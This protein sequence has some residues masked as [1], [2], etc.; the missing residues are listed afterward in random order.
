MNDEQDNAMGLR[1]YVHRLLDSNELMLR[2]TQAA[3]ELDCAVLDRPTDTGFRAAKEIG[4]ALR[5]LSGAGE[6][7]HE[8][9]LASM[10]YAETMERLA[11]NP[12]REK[13]MVELADLFSCDD[14]KEHWAALRD[15]CNVFAMRVIGHRRSRQ[16]IQSHPLFLL[17]HGL[18]SA[19]SRC[20]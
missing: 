19:G 3:T 15:F 16:R 9:L 12:L 11:D 18:A 10:L 5:Y 13:T 6:S 17:G 14:A 1:R 2:L 8:N 4:W 20:I 7:P